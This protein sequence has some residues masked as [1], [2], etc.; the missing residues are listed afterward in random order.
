[1]T[2]QE[3]LMLSIQTACEVMTCLS[4]DARLFRTC[5]PLIAFSA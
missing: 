5:P 3:F 4:N 1:M 2:R